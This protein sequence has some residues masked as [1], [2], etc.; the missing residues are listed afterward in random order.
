MTLADFV[1]HGVLDFK[2]LRIERQRILKAQGER[3]ETFTAKSFRDLTGGLPERTPGY[4]THK[5]HYHKFL[6]AV[7]TAL[8]GGMVAKETGMQRA[9]EQLECH[10]ER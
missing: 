7:S 10:S 9:R 1:L 8:S 3:T 6:G 4:A 2:A 5:E